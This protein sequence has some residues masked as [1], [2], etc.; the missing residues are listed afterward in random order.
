MKKLVLS[1][2]LSL[3]LA[4]VAGTGGAAEDS[5]TLQ[6]TAHQKVIH[7]P[8]EFKAYID[9]AHL[10]D[11]TKRGEAMERFA[12]KYPH[13]VAYDDALQQAMAAYQAAGSR[14]K[15]AEVG[16]RLLKSAPDNIQAL[17]VMAYLQMNADNAAAAAEAKRYAER[18]LKL[19]ADWHGVSGMAPAQFAAMRAQ[20]M[21]I[22]HGAV[23]VADLFAK[24]YA[25]ARAALR[26]TVPLDVNGFVDPYR[27]GVAE[28]EP[29]PPDPEGFWYVAKAVAL[30]R[31]QNPAAAK[32]IEAYGSAKYQRF[33]GSADGWETLV[34]TAAKEKSPPRGFTVKPAPG[35]R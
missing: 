32:K 8:T 2:L 14:K 7:D 25:G 16:A 28:L 19:L 18:G 27:L 20:T 26:K 12:A 21:A 35:A 15:V 17:A 9:A 6:S 5:K 31:R 4:C 22:F 13:S 29:N 23:G 34:A 11:A 10:K 33:H 3:S 24:D 30:A 1:L